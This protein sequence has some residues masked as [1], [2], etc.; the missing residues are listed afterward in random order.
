M[1]FDEFVSFSEIYTVAE[2]NFEPKALRASRRPFYAMSMRLLGD[3]D[4]TFD[5][6]E[7]LHAS[8]GDI[9]FVPKNV[10]YLID[11]HIE[12]H[13]IC[14]HFDM[15]NE[16]SLPAVFT[17]NDGE[18]FA[19][20]FKKLRD[21]WSEK[22][23][24]YMFAAAACMNNILKHA[25]RQN[26]RESESNGGASYAVFLQAKRFI[27]EGYASHELSVHSVARDCNIS[28]IYLRKIF[29]KFLGISPK[30]YIEKLRI[31]YATELLQS[32]YYTV[33]DVAERCGIS[34][35]KHFSVFY[36]ANTGV[37]PSKVIK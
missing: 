16:I 10:G 24:G 21:I 8:A 34:N 13:I 29:N 2:L 18:K 32:G 30:K 3:A 12:E 19:S 37:S 14:V 31:E 22:I 1:F 27:D 6:K 35:S 11:S 33:S 23:P 25:V 4:F 5:T 15:P 36:K 26:T 7:R 28:D 17:P 20:L 9:V